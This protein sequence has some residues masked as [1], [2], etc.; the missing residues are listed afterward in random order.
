VTEVVR[1]AGREHL[2]LSAP[3]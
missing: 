1:L 3:C 2:A